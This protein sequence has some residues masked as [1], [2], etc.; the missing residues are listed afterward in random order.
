VIAGSTAIAGAVVA[1]C[2]GL[3]WLGWQGGPA[4]RNGSACSVSATSELAEALVATG[5]PS[6]RTVPIANNFQSFE[7]VKKQVRGVRRC[8]SAAIDMCMVGDGTYDGYWERAV[9]PW[10]LAGG[11]AVLLAA[12]GTMTS[13]DGTAACLTRGHIAATNGRIHQALLALLT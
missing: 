13:M 11:A 8:G 9:N 4:L 3:E 5:F 6:D 2:L 1:P 12:G 10:D 7:R